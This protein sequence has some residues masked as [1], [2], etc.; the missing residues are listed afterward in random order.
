MGA[1]HVVVAADGHRHP[2]CPCHSLTYPSVDAVSAYDDD[3]ETQQ[4]ERAND[5]DNGSYGSM[6]QPLAAKSLRGDGTA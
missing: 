4:E 2:C 3:G 1:E 5:R 6:R